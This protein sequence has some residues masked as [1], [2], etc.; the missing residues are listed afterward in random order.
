MK[1]HP[2]LSRFVIAAAVGI[3]AISCNNAPRSD[4]ATGATSTPQ[5]SARD[6]NAPEPVLQPISLTGCLQEKSGTY[7]LTELNEPKQRDSS[8]PSVIAREK[9]EAALKAY[10]LKTNDSDQLK[11]L[12]GQQVRIDGTLVRQSTIASGSETVGT[13]GQRDAANRGTDRDQNMKE[14]KVK[15]KDLALVDVRTVESVAPAC[16]GDA[17][18]T[19]A[20]RQ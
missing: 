9:Q 4:E 16:G 13:S 2:Y 19:P 7:I 8:D 1:P 3:A 20:K 15:E 10:R 6:A 18:K 12:N 5:A 14:Q 11:S 17:A